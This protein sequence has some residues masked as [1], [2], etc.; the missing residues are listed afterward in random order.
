M[1]LL[2][3]RDFADAVKLRLLQW[4]GY[5][6]LFGWAPCNHK[7]PY[8]R[9]AERSRAEEGVWATEAEVGINVF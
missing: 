6:G 5:P 2:G 8:K 3:K 1:T 9:R 4:G 7:G